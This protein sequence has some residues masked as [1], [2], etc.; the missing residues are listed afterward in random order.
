MCIKLFF[1][2]GGY[3][4]LVFTPFLSCTSDCPTV[5]P[6]SATLSIDTWKL[7]R[8]PHRYTSFYPILFSCI[9]AYVW[10]VSSEISDVMNS[11]IIGGQFVEDG[12]SIQALTV[13]SVRNVHGQNLW[14]YDGSPSLEI[15]CNLYNP[16]SCSQTNRQHLVPTVSTHGYGIWHSRQLSFYHFL[17]L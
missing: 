16:H 15:D 17:F 6:R 5:N 7:C 2:T 8:L 14:P 11:A 13:Y 10:P 1:P 4:P 12:R 3:I 9:E